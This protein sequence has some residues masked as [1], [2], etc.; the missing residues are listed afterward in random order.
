MNN[1]IPILVEMQKLDDV[2]AEK[3]VLTESLPIRLSGLK[4]NVE[5][6]KI[7]KKFNRL[8]WV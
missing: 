1:H 4:K 8:K 6:V 3:L 7:K 5:D 2:I